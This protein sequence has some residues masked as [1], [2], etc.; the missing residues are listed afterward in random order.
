MTQARRGAAGQLVVMFGIGL[1]AILLSVGLVVDGGTAFLERRGGQNDA[2]VA[3]VAGTQIVA[4]AYTDTSRLDRSR[5]EVFAAISASMTRNG[6]PAGS[7]TCAWRARF[8]GGNQKELGQ[9]GAGDPAGIRGSGILGV[10]VDVTRS[11]RTFFLGLI[12]QS[13]WKIDTTATALTTRPKQAPAGQLL[14]M[15]LR[16]PVVPFKA[17]QIYDVT[18]G[19]TTPGGFVWLSWGGS[20][21]AGAL[22]SSLCNP[23]NSAFSMPTSISAGPVAADAGDTACL[24]DWIKG[25]STVLIPIFVDDVTDKMLT[26]YKIERLA[27]FVITGQPKVDELRVSFVGTY[28][29]PSAAAGS[30]DQPPDETDSLYYIGLVK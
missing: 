2:D 29:Y 23:N 21:A 22:H 15:A 30:G 19:K 20:S 18:A 12:G 27:A 1:L 28:G 26:R 25:K 10:R 3:A 13:S 17:G 7:T 11:P 5:G 16:E 8:V 4:D 24:S 14:P 9:V 6:C